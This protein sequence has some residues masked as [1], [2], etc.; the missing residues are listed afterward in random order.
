MSVIRMTD[1]DL[2]GKRVLIREDLNVPV[3]DGA[4]TSDARIRAALPTIEAALAG[5]AAV[6]LVSHLGRPNEGQ[7]EEKFSLRPVA[8]RLGE[9]LGRE[10]RLVE[11]WIDGVAVEPG[12]V[13]LLENVRFLAGEKT[14]DEAL[15]RKMAALCDIFV[16]DAFG[17]A[18]RAQA[19][20][21]GV[22]EHAPVA[23]AGP[24]LAR[25]LEALGKALTDPARPF[26]AIVG[27]SKV[28]TKLHVLDALAGMVDTLIVG[29][30]IANTFIAAAGNNVGKSLH[31][32]DM[33]DT[34]RNLAQSAEG[35]ASIPIPDDVV[36][37]TEFAAEAPA[38]VKAVEAVGDEELIL[39][40]G[41]QT[42]KRFAAIIREAGTIIW[43]GPV[44][45]FEFDAFG[46]GTRV[47]AEAIAASS[48]FSVA[49]GGDTLAAISKYGVAD[50]ISYISTG[51]GA[52]LEFV[53]GKTLPAV[54]MLEKR[55]AS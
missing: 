4:V 28:S 26:V 50:Q 25:E 53:E 41:P 34:A 55:A 18:H 47:L 46:D 39:D 6:M 40:I 5:N 15:S 21:Y 42:A 8:A 43:N 16:M 23:C 9:L 30:G 3:A 10:V 31:E 11:D 7:P 27:G 49:G 12:N 32:A 13:V 51:G 17:T 36:V 45:V 44:G 2:A 35:R 37:A 1:L 54:A 48:G 38:T 24:L 14:C 29:G 52:F 19:S 22:A 33:L 20:T